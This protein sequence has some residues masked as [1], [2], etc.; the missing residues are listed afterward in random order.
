[1]RPLFL[2]LHQN[3]IRESV[4][5]YAGHGPRDAALAL[6]YNPAC[7]YAVLTRRRRCIRTPAPTNARTP[8]RRNPMRRRVRQR[9]SSNARRTY[10]VQGRSTVHPS[11]MPSRPLSIDGRGGGWAL[12]TVTFELPLLPSLAAV[13]VDVPPSSAMSVTRPP[14]DTVATVSSLDP[15]VT[16]RPV[17]IL[18]LAS[19]SV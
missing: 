6:F 8:T 10:S 18:P 13:I 19:L 3:V 17:R 9:Y 7:G 14:A 12:P 1:M 11:P 16:V 5:Q 2:R 15:Q 4:R